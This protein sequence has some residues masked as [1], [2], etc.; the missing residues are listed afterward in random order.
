[1]TTALRRGVAT[2]VALVALLALVPAAL[3]AD[4]ITLRSL[5]T[6]RLPEV[7]AVVALDE[8]DPDQPPVFRVLEND[9]QVGSVE[10]GSAATATSYALVVDTSQSMKGRALR[11]AMEGAKTFLATVKDGD[12]V[13]LIGFG[14]AVLERQPFTDDQTALD[15]AV[16][17]LAS[18]PSR[19]PRWRTPSSPAPA[20]WPARTRSA[21]A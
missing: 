10:V 11:S 19:A 7:R 6:S 20:P 14:A 16:D 18:T 1:M 13:A 3:A 4:G 12:R 17:G 5:D 2:L 21:G 8:V 9:A 15:N